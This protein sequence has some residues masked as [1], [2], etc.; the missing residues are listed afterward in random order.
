M[1]NARGYPFISRVIL[2]ALV[3]SSTVIGSAVPASIL[4]AGPAAAK[5]SLKGC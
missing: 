5:C 4:F 3:L 1:E 2:F